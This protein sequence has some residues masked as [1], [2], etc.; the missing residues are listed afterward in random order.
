MI[1]FRTHPD[2]YRH[3]RLDVGGRVARLSL[4][5]DEGG[6]LGPYELKLNSYDLGVD[7]ELYDAVQRL[8]FEH[9]EVGAVLVDSL[10]ERVFCAGANISMLAQS[11][12]ELKVNFCK[13]TNET[14]N[15]IEDASANSGQRYVAAINGTAA[16][17]GYELALACD[18]IILIDDGSA[19]VSLPEVPLL[20]VLPGTGGLTRLVDKRSVRRDLADVLCTTEEGVK[21]KRALEWGLIDELAPGSQ[22]DA[23]VSARL[24]EIA[25]GSDRPEQAEGIPLE[26]LDRTIEADTVSYSYVTIDIDRAG[27]TARLEVRGPDAAPPEDPAQLAELGARFWPLALTRQL[28]DALLHLRVN[29]LEIGT[30]LFTTRGSPDLVLAHDGFLLDHQDDWLVR[31]IVLYLKR[32]LKRIDVTSRS[33]MAM[34]EPG[35][36][37][38]GFLAEVAFAAD[39]SYMLEGTFADSSEEASPPQ[40]GLTG[41]NFGPLPMSNGLARLETRFWG[42]PD[43]LERVG[44]H[45]GERLDASAA[46]KVGLVTFALDDIDWEDE[47]RLLLE[48]RASFSPDS[49]TGMEANLRFAGPE[50]LETKIFGRLS[51]W[52]NW[53]FQ[54][55]NASGE[56]GALRRYGTGLRPEYDRKRV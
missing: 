49:L 11:T 9:P 44:T 32:T 28:D 51:A 23:A 14:R 34:I 40:F 37:F 21:G 35:S 4:D 25:A 53:V 42:R 16:G 3:W 20:A 7:I 15:G 10:K 29:E 33:T 45:V 31:E 54:R 26:P 19:A 8:R 46:E 5:V 38:V 30:L 12:H 41:M 47:I 17:G 1:D 36:C 43:D 48:E 50:T 27:R 22:F 56:S 24:E 52:Q 13:F 39:R 2:E 18:H 6:G 55:S